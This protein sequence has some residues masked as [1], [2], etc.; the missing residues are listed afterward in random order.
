MAGVGDRRDAGLLTVPLVELIAG[1]NARWEP[2]LERALFGTDE[3]AE[4]AAAF[5]EWAATE[6]GSPIAAAH[7]YRTSVGATAGV[8]LAD[9]RAAV[10]KVNLPAHSGPRLQLS[11][12]VRARLAVAGFPAPRP[13][14]GI[15]RLRAGF[16][17]AEELLERGAPGDP[18]DPE[19]RLALSR[20]LVRAVELATPLIDELPDAA[21]AGR[22]LPAASS[23]W[24][25]AHDLRFDF[26]GTAAGA[27]WIDD[28]A[29]GARRRL[30]SA[31]LPP[32]IGHFDWRAE[33]VR[34]AGGEVVA[35][36]DWDSVGVGSHA[37]VAG[38]AA[39][40]F[41]ADWTVPER[42]QL[43]TVGESRAF[44]EEY[45]IARGRSFSPEERRVANAANTYAL[46]YM[47]RCEHSDEL[48][49]LFARRHARDQLR[50][51]LAASLLDEA[52]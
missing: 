24:P 22:W 13:L 6:L 16:A 26:A 40:A 19:L 47:S 33:H 39:F 12:A 21:N 29:A 51:L 50:E 23:L 8:Q 9:G 34:F 36:Y 49:G 44:L 48:L 3:P 20:S 27:E 14:S 41:T 52:P 46:A 18:H 4:I 28:A 10:I 32:V 30:R 1:S 38:Q 43:P 31:N 35:T 7:F 11:V 5:D 25:A 45:E 2:R 37:E 17:A 15:A 42:V